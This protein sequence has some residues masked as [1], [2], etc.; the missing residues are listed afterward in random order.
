M[1]TAQPITE[2][3]PRGMQLLDDPKLNHARLQA[4]NGPIISTLLYFP[5]EARN[6]S[7]ALFRPD[8]LVNVV[9]TG[10]ARLA[11]FNFVLC[12]ETLR[13]TSAQ[14]SRPSPILMAGGAYA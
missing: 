7:D 10:S 14:N 6:A 11:S 4:A 13:R 12:S 8:L 1:Q 9:D 5:G 3:A 2:N